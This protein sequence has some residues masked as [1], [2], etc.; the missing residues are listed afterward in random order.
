MADPPRP[1]S[2]PVRP[3]RPG[4]LAPGPGRA[5]GVAGRVTDDA[6]AARGGYRG[7]GNSV[8]A[9]ARRE[10]VSAGAGRGVRGYWPR[11]RAGVGGG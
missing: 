7:G 5:A 6:G 8:G 9:P 1:A 10:V 3:D 11:L 2:L 4:G